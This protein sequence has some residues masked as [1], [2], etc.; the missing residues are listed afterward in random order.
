MSNSAEQLEAAIALERDEHPDKPLELILEDA[1]K[2][3][4]ALRAAAGGADPDMLALL[5]KRRGSHISAKTDEL[6]RSDGAQRTAA[7][8]SRLKEDKS[9]PHPAEAKALEDAKVARAA[10]REDEARKHESFAANLRAARIS[11]SAAPARTDDELRAAA[12]AAVKRERPWLWLEGERRAERAARAAIRAAQPKPTAQDWRGRVELQ[13]ETARKLLD[14]VP[15]ARAHKRHKPADV[16]P[17]INVLA[18]AMRQAEPA[19]DVATSRQMATWLLTGESD[20]AKRERT[21]AGHLAAQD[22]K[23]RGRGTPV[24]SI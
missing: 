8:R 17:E 13:R 2:R 23:R 7:L 12:I 5:V 18:Q 4:A 22:G 19:M 14:K 21:L 20:P 24:N 16:E 15:I 3:I 1:P 9:P 11:R 10:G 6:A